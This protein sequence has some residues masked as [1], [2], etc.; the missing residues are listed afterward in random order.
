MHLFF[1]R[2]IY[3]TGIK[4]LMWR[5][6]HGGVSRTDWFWENFS[7]NVVLGFFCMSSSSIIGCHGW[8]CEGFM[9]SGKCEGFIWSSAFFASTREN[10]THPDG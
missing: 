9:E 4:D 3:Y 8:Q 10:S 1:C 5:Y 7:Q 2:V 6:C